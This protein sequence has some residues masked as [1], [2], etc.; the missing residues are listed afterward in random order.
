MF[1]GWVGSWKNFKPW[2]TRDVRVLW[3]SWIFAGSG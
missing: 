1:H 2:L 3:R